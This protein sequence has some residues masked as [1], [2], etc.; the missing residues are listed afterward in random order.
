MWDKCFFPHKRSLWQYIKIIEEKNFLSNI[1][2]IRNKYSFILPRLIF[3]KKKIQR[4]NI[5]N[6]HRS[7][8]MCSDEERAA[9]AGWWKLQS[10]LAECPLQLNPSAPQTPLAVKGTRSQVTGWHGPKSL[11]V[12][13]INSTHSTDNFGIQR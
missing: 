8:Y 9:W 3:K 11:I 10:G 6:I 4:N 7:H 1:S 2:R 5:L 13:T 12:H